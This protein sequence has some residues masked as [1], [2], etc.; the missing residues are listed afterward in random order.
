ML[1]GILNQR[2]D[3]KNRDGNLQS[4]RIDLNLDAQLLAEAKTL[5]FEIGLHDAQFLFERQ[6]G[7]LGFQEVA[8]NVRQVQ[9][10]V[11]RAAR[12]AR[13]NSVQR[14]QGVEQ[15]MRVDLRLQ[16]A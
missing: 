3:R 1:H 5:D 9:H 4:F 13:N 15:E 7:S 6:K 10:G 2:L 14:V 11:P 12:R 8:K 16:R